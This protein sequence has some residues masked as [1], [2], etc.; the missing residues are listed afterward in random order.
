LILEHRAPRLRDVV[1]DIPPGLDEI[2]A[3]ALARHPS[4]RYQSAMEMGDA[5]RDYLDG[6]RYNQSASSLA[7]LLDER[8]GDTVTRRRAV[9]EAALAGTFDETELLKALEARAVRNVDLFPDGEAQEAAPDDFSEETSEHAAESWKD[10]TDPPDV[11][12]RPLESGASSSLHSGIGFRV[13]LEGNGKSAAL[14]SLLQSDGFGPEDSSAGSDATAIDPTIE[15]GG[16]SEDLTTIDPEAVVQNLDPK[17][18]T[19]SDR[20]TENLVAAGRP[21]S[22]KLDS[23]SVDVYGPDDERWGDDR[24][25]AD[26]DFEDPGRFDRDEPEPQSGSRDL[27]VVVTAASSPGNGAVITKSRAPSQMRAAEGAVRT[28]E[29]LEIPTQEQGRAISE[30]QA[31]EPPENDPAEVVPLLRSTNEVQQQISNVTIPPPIGDTRRYTFAALL[32]AVGF[33]I[34]FGLVCGLLLARLIFAS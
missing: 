10:P 20:E 18:R 19:H 7:K 17:G 6:I 8:F 11:P 21:A 26:D 25:K 23:T 3:K 32:A 9:F 24:T 27:G 5:L 22:G 13:Q 2:C 29:E 28:V 16:A 4:K 31:Y 15:D 34:S 12:T 33:G 1:P 30:L 14:L